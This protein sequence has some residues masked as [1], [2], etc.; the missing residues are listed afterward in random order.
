[1]GPKSDTIEDTMNNY[2][3]PFISVLLL[4]LVCVPASVAQE[5]APDKIEKADSEAARMPD[6]QIVIAPELSSPTMLIG[7]NISMVYPKLVPRVT[8]Q[9]RA[10]RLA[11]LAKWKISKLEFEDRGLERSGQIKKSTDAMSSVTF[12]TD[13]PLVDYQTGLLAI[14]PFAIAM[15]DLGRVNVM[16]M[17]PGAFEYKGVKRY[18]DD[19]ISLDF[20]GDKGVYSYMLQIKNHQASAYNLPIREAVAPAKTRVATSEPPATKVMRWGII[21]ALAAGMG[22]LVYAIASRLIK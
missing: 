6:A 10:N 17:V 12:R 20:A 5:K 2:V 13:A 22:C 11:A 15:R 8:V 19:N 16:Y 18:N 9:G 3:G 14:E 21:V 4:G 1:M 7:W